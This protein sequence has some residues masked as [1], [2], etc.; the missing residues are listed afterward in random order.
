M[1]P[2]D[3]RDEQNAVLMSDSRDRLPAHDPNQKPIFSPG[4]VISE[5][6]RVIRFIARGGMGEVYE[7]ED[8]ELQSRIALKTIA[9][10]RASSTKQ[11]ARFRQ[12]I[13]LARKVS[14]PNVCRV[15][16]LG[17]HKI[18]ASGGN[19]RRSGDSG[20]ADDVLFLTM[21][22]LPGETL[23]SY[24]EKHGPM[25]TEQALP[26][27]RQ[28]VSALAAAHHLGIVHRDFKPGNVMLEE[29]PHGM[30][31]KVTDFGL[32]TNPEADKTISRSITQVLGT[33][34]YMAPEQLRG[35][36]SNRTDIFALGLTVFQMLTGALPISADTASKVLKTSETGKRGGYRWR[37]AIS[38]SLA[39]NPAERFAS[40]EEFW[41]AL[42]GERVPGQFGWKA[43]AASTRRY[44][45]L[46]AIAACLAI[47]GIAAVL[48]GVVP[49]PFRRLPQQKHIA[50]LPFENIGHDASNQAFAE[51]VAEA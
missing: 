31:A 36:C 14:H 29:T 20:S 39:T 12:E 45:I 28:L 38:K 27:V 9:P 23:S 17:R 24:L 4:D 8:W 46:Y 16:D 6:Y 5:R 33:P 37:G 41:Y 35:Q 44:W 47:G 18:A 19:A 34:E 22:L 3:K 7:V 51:G 42:S 21:E 15:F 11:V 30:V 26:I 13:Q 48:T 49:N 1:E 43:I 32:A 50:V 2:I 40:V 25:T 10:E